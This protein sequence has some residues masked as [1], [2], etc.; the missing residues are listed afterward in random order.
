VA[1]LHMNTVSDHPAL[2]LV[3]INRQTG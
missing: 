3:N 1:C 2:F